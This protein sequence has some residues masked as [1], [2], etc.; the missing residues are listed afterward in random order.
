MLL[1][2]PV[3][4]FCNYNEKCFVSWNNT[5]LLACTIL[6]KAEVTSF[7]RNSLTNAEENAD[8]ILAYPGNSL[9]KV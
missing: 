1:P 3:K 6:V 2:I 5:K 8:D 7:Y 4:S 9:H